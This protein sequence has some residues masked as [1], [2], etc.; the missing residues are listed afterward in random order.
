MHQA[1]GRYTITINGVRYMPR[2]KAI[3][4][5]AGL[6]HQAVVNH[7]GTV[8]RTTMAKAVTAELTFDRGKASNNTQRPKWDADFMA[9]FY[10]ITLAETDANVQ[11][12]F[13]NATIVGEPKIDTET[14]EVT[15]L[16]I[17]CAYAD[18]TQSAIS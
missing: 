7:D 16:S 4:D 10:D 13:S 1:G 2:G 15:G 6:Q 8:G 11:H 9:P 18:Y 3:V 12:N 14:G 5:P 17:A